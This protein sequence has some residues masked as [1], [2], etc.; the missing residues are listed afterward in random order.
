MQRMSGCDLK[1][2]TIFSWKWDYPKIIDGQKILAWPNILNDLFQ[3]YLGKSV[4]SRKFQ[5]NL[6]DIFDLKK[7]L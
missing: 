5:P 2:E 6:Q 3:D 1:W 4:K 7:I